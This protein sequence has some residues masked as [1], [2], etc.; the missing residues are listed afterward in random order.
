MSKNFAFAQ[1][2]NWSLSSNRL[3][4]TVH[5]LREDKIP[6]FDLTNSN[7][8]DCQFR[9][10]NQK[11]LR[12]LGQKKNLTYKPNPQGSLEAREA[13]SRYYKEKGFHVQPQHIFLTSST[14]EGYSFLFR[15]LVDPQNQVLFPCPSYPLF[16]YLVDLNDIVMKNYSLSYEGSWRIDFKQMRE[17]LTTNTKAVV[18]VNPNNPTGSYILKEELSDLNKICRERNTALIGDEVFWDFAFDPN[19]QHLS[20]IGNTEVLT[21]VLG[22]IS[23]ILGLPQMKL[24]WIIL[25]GPDDLVEAAVGR[26]EV[27]SDTYLSV[28]T[29][30]QNSLNQWLSSKEEIF[31]EMKLRIK[32]NISFLKTQC[33]SASP[34]RLLNAQGGWYAVL[35]IPDTCSEEEWSLK[36]LTEDH[37]FVHPGYFFDFKEEPIIVLS[38]LP[39]SESFQ[40]GVRRILKRM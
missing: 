24:S 22:G 40:E 14:S 3:M 6:L 32:G 30:A 17:S 26:L 11:I 33:E 25:S 15:L 37:V 28:S 34:C 19:E 12:P 8:T 4:K 35:R 2:T 1:R 38:L 7:P 9:F 16:Q 5:K 36:F 29:P 10:L 31:K 27:I 18:L 21:F 13:V 20:L 23:K 39:P